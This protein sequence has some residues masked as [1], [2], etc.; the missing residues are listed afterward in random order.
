[1]R[2]KATKKK[3]E[4]IRADRPAEGCGG[5]SRNAHMPAIKCAHCEA[6]GRVRRAANTDEIVLSRVDDNSH[7][8]CEDG[9]HLQREVPHPVAREYELE[10]HDP[11]AALPGEA[12]D[13]ERSGNLG[14]SEERVH[15]A[16]VVAER[17]DL[18][19]LAD[20]VHVAVDGGGSGG[21]AGRRARRA[22]ITDKKEEKKKS[23][24]ARSRE[25]RAASR[26]NGRDE[27]LF[28]SPYSPLSW[29]GMSS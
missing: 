14:L 16:E 21:G 11:V 10:R 20:V 1:M 13:A 27:A 19:L 4:Q 8:A 17:G 25:P 29:K 15:L 18:A 22:R 23:V 9:R 26:S 2:T 3:K 7:A 24:A 12:R 5:R 28:L 6:R